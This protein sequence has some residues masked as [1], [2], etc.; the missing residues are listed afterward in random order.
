MVENKKVSKAVQ[1]LDAIEAA[2]DGMSAKECEQYVSRM[3]LYRT[4]GPHGGRP[5]LLEVF[6]YKDAISK[7]WYRNDVEHLGHPYTVM[8]TYE[9]VQ[10]RDGSWRVEKRTNQEQ[11]EYEAKERE[12][13]VKERVWDKKFAAGEFTH[14]APTAS[15]PKRSIFEEQAEYMA[16]ALRLKASTAAHQQPPQCPVA[17]CTAPSPASELSY[18]DLV[19]LVLKDIALVSAAILK[20]MG[21]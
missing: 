20:Q 18:N 9:H 17:S 21:R 6:C 2:F 1:F 11:A 4:G 16:A 7:R 8:R 3:A 10:N 12:S 13:R 15:V 19:A 14:D 5:G